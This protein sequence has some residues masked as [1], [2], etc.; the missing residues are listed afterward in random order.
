MALAPE[1]VGRL[2]ASAA[3]L[4]TWRQSGKAVEAD[5][6]A[7]EQLHREVERARRIR[8]LWGGTTLALALVGVFGLLSVM[9][10]SLAP[11]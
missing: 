6:V 4:T 9:L 3:L 7:F 5:H 1:D 2:V 8:L 10:G 11:N